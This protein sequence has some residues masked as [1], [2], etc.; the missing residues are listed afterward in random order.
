MKNKFF[1]LGSNNEIP[2]GKKRIFTDG[3]SSRYNEFN[4]EIDIDLSHDRPNYTPK[5]YKANTSTEVCMNFINDTPDMSRDV[6]INDHLDVDGIL[7]VF[8]LIHPKIA[9]DNRSLIV[10]AA[11]IGDFYAWGSSESQV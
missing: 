1:I 8:T 9:L 3:S 10:Q 2:K 7:S 11:E 5:K 6:I 4:L